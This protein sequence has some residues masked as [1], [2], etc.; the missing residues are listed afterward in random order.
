MTAFQKDKSNPDSVILLCYI[1]NNID[2]III[3]PNSLL[4]GHNLESSNLTSAD[5]HM[6]IKFTKTQT[7]R[8]SY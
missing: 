7:F 1:Y 8:E 2:D 5:N 3:T 4:F 6:G